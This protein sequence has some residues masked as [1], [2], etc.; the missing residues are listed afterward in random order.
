MAWALQGAVAPGRGG[1]EGLGRFLAPRGLNRS[2]E[3]LLSPDGGRGPRLLP[4]DP[5]AGCAPYTHTLQQGPL[6]WTLT[7]GQVGRL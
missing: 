4:Q 3:T 7:K 2:S 6:V 1:L 5:V